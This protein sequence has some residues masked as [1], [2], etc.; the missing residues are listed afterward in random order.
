MANIVTGTGHIAFTPVTAPGFTKDNPA[1]D[2]QMEA[3]CK[4]MNAKA[5]KMGL[6]VRYEVSS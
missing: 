6:A 4:G 2:E 3:R 1:N 5:E